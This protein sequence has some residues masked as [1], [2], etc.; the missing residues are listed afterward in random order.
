MPAFSFSSLRVRLLLL[1][2]ISIIPALMLLFY[3]ASV[4]RSEKEDET[5]AATMRAAKLAANNLEH[6]MEGTHQ[7]F[8]ALA[9]L[10]GIYNN[11]TACNAAFAAFKK[12]LPMYTNMAL[13]KKNGDV[14]CSSTPI[15]NRK[16]NLADRLHVRTAVQK[17]VFSFGEYTVGRIVPTQMIGVAQPVLDDQHQLKGVVV[18][19][20]DL[21]WLIEQLDKIKMI[22]NATLNVLD[23][24]GTVLYRYPDPEKWIGKDTSDL[25]ITKT[26]LAQGEGIM[27]AEGVDGQTRLYAF[28]PVQGTDKGMYVRYGVSLASAFADINLMLTRNVIALL[29]IACMAVAVAWFGGNYFIMHR[30]RTLM[31]ATDELA[32]GNLRARVDVADQKDE[33]GQLGHSFNAMATALGR[34]SNEQKL[35]EEALIRSEEKYRTLFE[36]SK[37]AIFMSTPEGTYLDINPAGLELFGYS[38]KEELFKV[39][40]SKDIY[41]YPEHRDTYQN[42]LMEKGYVKDYEIEMKRKDGKKLTVLSTTTVVRNRNGDIV[43]YRGIMR[44]IT[45]HK[46]LEQQLL[47][48]QKMEAVGQLAGGIAHD[49][50]NIL[51]AISGYGNLLKK[52]M[53]NEAVLKEYIEQILDAASRATEVTRSL[54]AFSRKQIMNPQPV[55]VNDIVKKFEKLLS[56]IIGEDIEVITKLASGDVVCLADAGRIEQVLMNLATNARDAMSRGGKL[57]LGTGLVELDDDFIRDHGYGNRGTYAFISVSDTGIGMKQETLVKIFEPFFTTKD[58][59]KGTGLGLAMVYGIIKQHDGYITVYSKPDVGTTFRIYLPATTV[60]EDVHVKTAISPVP[61]QGTETVLVVEDDGQLLRLS[62]IVLA[63]SGYKVISARDGEEAIAKFIENKDSIQLV[64][65]DVLMPKKSGTEAYVEMRKIKPDS[66]VIFF[67]GYTSDKMHQH[68]L[69]GRHADLLIK[70]VSPEDLLQKVREVLD[71]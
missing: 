41:L 32:K 18:A 21:K 56:R 19:S 65:M 61:K 9:E 59:G 70:P 2:I 63:Q 60:Q 40:I 15:R 71:R 42:I 47:Q 49:F 53:S 35:T 1:I 45:E 22:E 16:V 11:S 14:M 51:T 3:S 54:L 58:T 62:E 67:S 36:E 12:Q 7:V 20:I 66:K 38:S 28:T 48:A 31:R 29:I 52:K 64:I 68:S 37:D 30:I 23:R 57:T 33:I 46:R 8:T 69:R 44:D 17:K 27:I 25:K 26:T 34:H 13:V 43:A 5:R 39:N 4:Q 10:P 24:N 6:I 55:D 50:N